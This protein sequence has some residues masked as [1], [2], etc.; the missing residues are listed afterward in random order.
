MYFPHLK[1]KLLLHCIQYILFPK[2]VSLLHHGLRPPDATHV[3]AKLLGNEIDGPSLGTAHVKDQQVLPLPGI[4]TDAGKWMKASVERGEASK[5]PWAM[6][7]CALF[8][9][10]FE[11]L[12][13]HT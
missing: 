2:Y 8:P 6:K 1:P 3:R 13:Y 9:E 4:L 11:S 12:V 10:L 5:F 7:G